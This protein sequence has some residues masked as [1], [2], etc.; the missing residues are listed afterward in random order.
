MKNNKNIYNNFIKRFL[1][2]IL[3]IIALI[4]LSPI[5]LIL[6]VA[7]FVTQGRPIFFSQTR[8]G[9]NGK[10]FKMYKFR[11]MTLT[12][13]HLNLN[14]STTN[15]ITPLGHFLRKTSLDELPQILNILKGEMSFIGPR[16]WIPEIYEFLPEKSKN[17]LSV[18]PG[19]SGYAQ[20]N[21][22]NGISMNQKVE[23][24]LVY[25]NNI[26]FFMDLYIFLK[27]FYCIISHENSDIS[28]K[29]LVDEIKKLQYNQERG[30]N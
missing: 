24:D 28:E 25:I 22:R 18:L 27:T 19:L 21:G 23:L 15:E 20:I 14:S 5:Y 13:N 2:I 30:I 16:P 1:D 9:L 4:I 26:S 8:I 17:R 3:A 29:E 6:I 10:K 12:R 7:I 11:T